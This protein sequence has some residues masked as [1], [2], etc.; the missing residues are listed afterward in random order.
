MEKT[1]LLYQLT[2]EEFQ[3]LIKKAVAAEF[4]SFKDRLRES[5]P[6]QLLTRSEACDFLKINS[7][8]LW[9]WTKSGKVQ[10]YGIGN[11][12]YYKKQELTASLIPLRAG[13]N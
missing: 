8:T 3:L 1:V 10:A 7:T 4:E 12:V 11:R 5:E 9:N 13:R 2:P 6:D